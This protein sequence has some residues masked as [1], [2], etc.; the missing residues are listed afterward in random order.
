M[1]AASQSDEGVIRAFLALPSDPDWTESARAFCAT[2]RDASPPAAWA[3]PGAWHLTVR[4]FG[5]TPAATLGPLASILA[6]AAAKAPPE[7]LAL[8][9]PAVF[10][11]RGPARVLAIGLPDS[12]TPPAMRDLAEAA[13][14]AA[15][16]L[17]FAPEDRPFRPHVTLARLRA[18]WPRRA[19][20]AFRSAAAR[21]PFPAWRA[22][23][24]LLYSSRL[25]RAGAV[26]TPLF[27]WELGGAG[28]GG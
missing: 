23:A 3:P 18:P 26:H 13:E 28:V 5:N 6:E 8:R 15:R 27:E 24:C 22:R 11:S 4:F 1:S 25:R 2:F 20:D 14:T 19:V 7:D 16:R 10:P 9:E 17:G 12:G 21:W